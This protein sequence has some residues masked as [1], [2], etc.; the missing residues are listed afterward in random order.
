MNRPVIRNKVHIWTGPGDSLD[1]IISSDIVVCK[2]VLEQGREKNRSM[3][4]FNI[5]NGAIVDLKKSLDH[6]IS[7]REKGMDHQNSLTRICHS[8]EQHQTSDK[9]N[10]FEHYGLCSGKVSTSKTFSNFYTDPF[11]T[12]RFTGR[13]KFWQRDPSTS[14][15]PIGLEGFRFG[16]PS[17]VLHKYL[18]QRPIAPK[19]DTMHLCIGFSLS[20]SNCVA[21]KTCT[22]SQLPMFCRLRSHRASTKIR[23]HLYS[24]NNRLGE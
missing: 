3:V 15:E 18:N 19:A 12:N 5:F 8:F 22:S 14:K 23:R 6:K 9:A 21:I 20:R 4:K 13:Q 16:R 10:K 7:L 11:Y 2:L 24:T 1:F 17:G